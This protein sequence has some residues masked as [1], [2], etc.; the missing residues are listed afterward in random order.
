[1]KLKCRNVFWLENI[2][3]FFCDFALIPLDSMSLSSR[4]NAVTRLVVIVFFVLLLLDFKYSLSFLLVSLLFIIILYYIQKRNMESYCPE[5]N[6]RENYR[7]PNTKEISK[8][9]GHV[10]YRE[11]NTKEISKEGGHVMY[12]ENYREPNVLEILKGDDSCNVSLV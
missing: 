10:M 8:E 2:S 4:L 11:P 3:D 5:E 1:M 6:Y 7:E 12:R 9:G